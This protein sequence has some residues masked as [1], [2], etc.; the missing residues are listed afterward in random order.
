GRNRRSTVGTVTEIADHLRLLWARV[1]R[2]VCW[3]CGREIA[4]QTVQQVVDQLVVLA[5]D[6]RLFVYAPVVRDRKGEHRKELDE[7]RRAGFVRVRV[8]GTVREL[9]EDIVLARTA[10][11]TIDVLVDRLV[12]RPGVQTRLA[13]S[14]AVGF[15]HGA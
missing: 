9:G 10:R 14:L 15:A 6:T 5:P 3:S 11:H 2:A 13:D 12:L 7:L 4:A 8:D 1:G